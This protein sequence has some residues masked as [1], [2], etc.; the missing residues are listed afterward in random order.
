LALK[1]LCQSTTSLN[2]VDNFDESI[3]NYSKSIALFGICQTS[4]QLI[5]TNNS[6]LPFNRQFTDCLVQTLSAARRVVIIVN[7]LQFDNSANQQSDDIIRLQ[8]E[9]IIVTYCNSGKY[10]HQITV[11]PENIILIT[12]LYQINQ[13]AIQ[14]AESKDAWSALYRRSFDADTQSL[15]TIELRCAISSICQ[16]A[17]TLIAGQSSSDSYDFSG[18]LDFILNILLKNL[19]VT[20][21]IFQI[22]MVITD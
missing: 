12:V 13:C 1:H 22:I 7:C 5:A 10:F 4:T 15:Y 19:Y 9:V 8:N 18:Y 6:V 11:I 3:D 17:L 2:I 14:F 21:G 16:R 20:Y